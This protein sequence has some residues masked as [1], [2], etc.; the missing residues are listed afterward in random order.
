MKIKK[1][2][3]FLVPSLLLVGILP[4]TANWQPM[5]PWWE[6]VNK[7]KGEVESLYQNFDSRLMT[8]LGEYRGNLSITIG[9][10][11]L[12]DIKELEKQLETITRKE[13]SDSTTEPEIRHEE[14]RKI[15]REKSYGTLSKKGQQQQ[16]QKIDA[17]ENKANSAIIQGQ[18]A[19]TR[20]VTQEVL[21]DIALQQ[22]ELTATMAL[23]GTEIMDMSQ[24]QDLANINLTN[25]SEGIDIQNLSHKNDR[26]GAAYSVLSLTGM[27][28]AGFHQSR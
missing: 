11:G 1:R 23:V 18:I 22:A 28:S 26:Q 25:L 20:L 24:K 4:A 19:Q 5:I 2:Y 14:E 8:W 6:Q 27:M 21:K 3:F 17:L 9:D 16:K 12:P 7:L 10:M 15:I 13:G